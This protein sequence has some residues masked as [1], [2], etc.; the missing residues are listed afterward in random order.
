MSMLQ[1]V[2]S[3]CSLRVFR[4]GRRGFHAAYCCGTG[5]ALE[6]RAYG[7]AR[8]QAWL[9]WIQY[10]RVGVKRVKVLPHGGPLGM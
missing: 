8:V 10:P 5:G 3:F 9:T 1:N 7:M 4:S 6:E 2:R